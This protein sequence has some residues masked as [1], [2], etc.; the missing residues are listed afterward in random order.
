M[1][2]YGLN[3][4][5]QRFRKAGGISEI[6]L[7]LTRR[8]PVKGTETKEG[9]WVFLIYAGGIVKKIIKVR[10]EGRGGNMAVQYKDAVIPSKRP[11][12][13]GGR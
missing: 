10:E 4:A 13:W 12:G 8:P 6:F 3:A 9:F 5:V 2:G 11:P 7:I 1:V